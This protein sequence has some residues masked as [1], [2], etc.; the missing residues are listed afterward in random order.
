[1]VAVFADEGNHVTIANLVRGLISVCTCSIN[2]NHKLV[3]ANIA[4]LAD[5]VSARQ[6]IHA[7]RKATCKSVGVAD[8]HRSYLDVIARNAPRHTVANAIANSWIDYAR[9]ATAHAHNGLQV[10]AGNG[11]LTRMKSVQAN[12]HANHIKLNVFVQDGARSVVGVNQAQLITCV[13]E[14]GN[15]FNKAINLQ[16]KVPVVEHVGCS[17]MRKRA[18]AFKTPVEIDRTAYLEKIFSPDT[19]TGH[20]GINGQVIAANLVS[21]GGSLSIGKR[22][23]NRVDGRHDVKAHEVWNGGDWRLGKHQNGV[24]N[25]GTAQ[26][27]A[28]INRCNGK[29]ISTHG[30]H[31]FSALSSTVTVCVSLNHAHHF[32]TTVKLG[33]K[34]FYVVADG[35]KINL[36]PSPS[37][38]GICR[39][40]AHLLRSFF[41]VCHRECNLLFKCIGGKANNVTDVASHS[42]AYTELLGS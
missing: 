2:S 24:I 37:I 36:Y 21:C 23:V 15:R 16:V 41:K 3:H 27:N 39:H 12:A 4:H 14:R 34:R 6:N 17:K 26:L 20:A 5:T 13:F 30:L 32:D 22:K 1:M 29:L 10:N 33:L 42:S 40:Q 18:S 9:Y 11:E 8:R 38:L 28:L 7:V 31:G 35:R 19:N 25:T